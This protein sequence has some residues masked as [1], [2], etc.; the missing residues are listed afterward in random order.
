MK[1]TLKKIAWRCNVSLCFV[2]VTIEVVFLLIVSLIFFVLSPL[3]AFVNANNH[4]LESPTPES[5][6]QLYKN[7]LTWLCT[8]DLPIVVFYKND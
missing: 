8:E 3:L 4:K 7:A 1:E 5:W 6:W 2:L